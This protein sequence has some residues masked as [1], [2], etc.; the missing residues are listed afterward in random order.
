MQLE[1][2]DGIGAV[3]L[4]PGLARARRVG[5]RRERRVVVYVVARGRAVE[6]ADGRLLVLVAAGTREDTL[7]VLVGAERS[8]Y[9]WV[10]GR[11]PGWTYVDLEVGDGAEDQGGGDEGGGGELHSAG[12]LGGL[13]FVGEDVADVWLCCELRAG[14]SHSVSSPLYFPIIATIFD[15]PQQ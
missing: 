8:A 15:R 10:E 11:S 5:C 1:L 14:D 6:G 9:G 3:A 12:V 7:F 2:V 13:S 4:A